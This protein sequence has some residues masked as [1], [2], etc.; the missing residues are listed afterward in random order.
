MHRKIINRHAFRP[1]NKMD[2]QCL[3]IYNRPI[4]SKMGMLGAFPSKTTV[5]GCKRSQALGAPCQ[6]LH[7]CNGD[8]VVNNTCGVTNA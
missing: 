4:N 3:A 8:T 6:Y 7:N 5:N 2:P 1:I